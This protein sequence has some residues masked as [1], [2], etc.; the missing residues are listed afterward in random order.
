VE[1][2]C[3]GRNALGPENLALL[4]DLFDL[5]LEALAL[6]PPA[7]ERS[8]TADKRLEGRLAVVGTRCRG[9]PCRRRCRVDVDLQLGRHRCDRLRFRRLGFDVALWDGKVDLPT[10]IARG[11][12][13][14]P[15]FAQQR[16]QANVPRGPCPDTRYRAGRPGGPPSRET[17]TRSCCTKPRRC[18]PG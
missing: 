11:S 6:G 13:G 16:P 5:P 1:K 12:K 10:F 8:T 14:L 17:R 15:S 18:R 2:R 4:L 7:V 9:R 3:A